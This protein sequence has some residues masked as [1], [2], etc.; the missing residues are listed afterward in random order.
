MLLQAQLSAD[1]P[2]FDEPAAYV[3]IIIDD[4]GHNKSRGQLALSL[5][6]SL[7]Y[8]V[9]PNSRYASAVAESAFSSNREVIVHLPMENRNSYPMSVDALTDKLNRADFLISVNTL[10]NKVPHAIGINN[11]QGS[12]LTEQSVQMNWLMDDLK[13]RNFLFLD[14]RTSPKT[15][16]YK[17]ALNKNILSGARDVFLDNEPTTFEI[18]RAFQKLI[19]IAKRHGTAIGIG[20]PHK[21]TLDYLAIA[22]PHLQQQGITLL[23]V[24]NVMAVQ[25]I[26]RVAKQHSTQS[27]YVLNEHIQKKSKTR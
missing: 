3:A 20:H 8:A 23:P 5:P 6:G 11:H 10:I 21:Q 22:I 25:G 12:Y 18:D 17:I 2:A 14:S 15:V 9:L 7:T 19:R 27:T 26:Q 13:D 16:A 24:S 4:L 1:E